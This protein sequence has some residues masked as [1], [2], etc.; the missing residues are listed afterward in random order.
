SG[1]ELRHRLREHCIAGRLDISELE[2]RLEGERMAP[3]RAEL[4]S[5]EHDLRNLRRYTAKPAPRC[6]GFGEE[7]Q[8]PAFACAGRNTDL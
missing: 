1:T 2:E 4:A 7:A 6:A 5:L 8:H 3:T